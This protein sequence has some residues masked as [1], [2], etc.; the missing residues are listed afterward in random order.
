MGEIIL[1]RLH[2]ADTAANLDRQ[3]RGT[4]NV[5]NQIGVDELRVL[6]AVQIDHMHLRRACLG[7]AL[8]RLIG[9]RGDLL[10]CGI[11]ALQQPDSL[12]AVNINRG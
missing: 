7:K 8:R 6:C 11:V 5:G 1:H 2:I 9:R 12:A 10:G 3:S 4:G